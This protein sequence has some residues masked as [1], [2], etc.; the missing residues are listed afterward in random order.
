M[1]PGAT[2][3]AALR[4]DPPQGRRVEVVDMSMGDEHAIDRGQIRGGHARGDPPFLDDTEAITK[5]TD[6]EHNSYLS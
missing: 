6:C 2:T 1:T 4:V 3:R 5:V